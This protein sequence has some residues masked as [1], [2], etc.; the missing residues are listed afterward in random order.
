MEV[1]PTT[2]YVMGGIRVDGE[3]QMSTVP[4]LFAAGECAAGLHG[5]N[6]LGGKSLSDLIVFGKLAG[7]HVAQF[8][9]EN[10]HGNISDESV[11][12]ALEEALA[13]LDSSR[14]EV[15]GGAYQIQYEL[16]DMMQDKVGIV[17]T[18]S[19]MVEA[20]DGIEELKTRAQSV[21]APGNRQY[22]P[23][24]HTALDLHNLLLVSEAVSR[25][26][27]VRKE[28]RGGHTRNDFPEK[29]ENFSHVNT[30]VRQGSDGQ[31]EVVQ[32]SIPEMPED[33]KQIIEERK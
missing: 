4:G 20:I 2:H 14:A 15:P 27:I 13:P 28:S 21:S 26:A 19:E 29:D 9:K 3:T 11:K 10:G 5:A 17:R 31:M 23:G 22:N 33:L 25:S 16:Q 24:W 30:V 8:A 6:R 18:E 12:E 7:E 1:G 32:E